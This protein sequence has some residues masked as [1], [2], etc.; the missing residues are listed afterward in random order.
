MKQLSIIFVLTALV[1]EVSAQV[2][3]TADDM[4]TVIGQYY[5]AY[6]SSAP[7]DV[8]GIAGPAGGDQLWNF[9]DG[10]TDMILA[11]DIVDPQD[12]G[13]GDDFPAAEWCERQGDENAPPQARWYYRLD[14]GAI[15]NLG[16]WSLLVS[17]T[18]PSVPFSP[19]ITEYPVPL[20]FGDSWSGSTEFYSTIEYEGTMFDVKIEMTLNSQVDAWGTLLLPVTAG[21]CLRVDRQTSF[22]I[23]TQI[24]G[25]WILLDT[26]HIRSY[27]WLLENRG[28]AAQLVS[29]EADAPPPEDFSLAHFIRQLE[30]N[31]TG[32]VPAA[33]TDLTATFTEPGIQLNWSN[34]ETAACYR[35]EYCI[36]PAFSGEIT[37]L[38]HVY[39]T[40]YLDTDYSTDMTRFYRV[41]SLN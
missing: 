6:S 9:R 10:P 2:T 5:R 26:Y 36:D 15:T 24:W 29:E 25:V 38:A 31:H 30:T 39:A 13:H 41:V 14:P 34:A 21:D 19:P 12:G 22:D 32:G 1:M 17:E 11:G 28:V 37:V 20:H 16:A 4:F 27:L 33:V 18:D 8:T 23:Y 3:I 7:V 35:V 40:E